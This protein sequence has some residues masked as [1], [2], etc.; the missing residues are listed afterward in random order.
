MI[1]KYT[2]SIIKGLNEKAKS[3]SDLEHNLLKGRLREY[4]ISD[5]LEAY[6]TTQL[7][8]G[9]GIIINQDGEQSKETDIIIYDKRILPPFIIN[10]NLGIYPAECV[11]ST[12]EV[13]SRLQKT[14]IKESNKKAK[15]L[16]E[17]I[18]D[19]NSDYYKLYDKIKPICCTFGYW[20]ENRDL[21]KDEGREWLSN[22]VDS[23]L[24]ICLINKYCWIKKRTWTLKNHDADNGETKRFIA[25]LFDNLRSLSNKRY[26]EYGKLH[27][28]WWSIYIR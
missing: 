19:V 6:C 27:T 13:K 11:L 28:D 23:L 2:S 18:Y 8:I 24:L 3:I 25:V 17:N 1:P 10:K 7:G 4:F 16:L 5:I 15:Y 12:I 14:E 22:N 26:L 21:S 9:S 20:G